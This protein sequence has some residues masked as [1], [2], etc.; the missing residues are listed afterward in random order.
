[1]PSPLGRRQKPPVP[2]RGIV[3]STYNQKVILPGYGTKAPCLLTRGFAC[4]HNEATICCM[5]V[6]CAFEGKYYREAANVNHLAIAKT[7]E[8]PI[9]MDTPRISCIDTAFI[10]DVPGRIFL[11]S[12]ELT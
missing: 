7:A 8:T 4:V 12:T 9:T 11:Q 1:M 2:Q 6:I 5:I 3:D 10:S